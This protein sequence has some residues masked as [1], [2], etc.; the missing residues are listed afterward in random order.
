M[1]SIDQLWAKLKDVE[2]V[3]VRPSEM[4]AIYR[5]IF[6]FEGDAPLI[7]EIG[8]AHGASSII[9][10]EAVK[11]I[12]G[13]LHCFDTYPENYYDQEKFGEYAKK[14]FLKNMQPYEKDYF[15]H[16]ADSSNVNDLTFGRIYVAFI[17]GMHS[18]EAVKKDCENILPL[19]RS[20]GY[21]AFHDYNNVAFSGVKKAADEACAGWEKVNDVWDLVIFK[22]P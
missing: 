16:Q 5:R 13:V 3:Q 6:E 20:G 15:F 18:Y 4:E 11:E 12:G 9:L 22:K 17:D 21:V 19:M 7:V 10:A 1:K 8:S 14:A 2:L